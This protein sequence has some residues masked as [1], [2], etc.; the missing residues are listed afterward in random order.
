MALSPAQVVINEI[1]SKNS[2]VIL[3]NDSGS[4][5]WI[6]LYNTGNE[7]INL[8]NW[9][10][11]NDVNQPAKWRFPAIELPAD[12]HLVVMASGKNRKVIVDHWETIIHAEEIWKYWIPYGNPDPAW[13]NLNFDDSD[14][15]EGPGGFGRGDGDDNTILPD[16]VA[17]VYIRKTFTI[18]DTAVIKFASLHIDYD[19]AFVAYING[20]EVAR[21]NIGWPG[22][23]QHWD[24]F[25]YGIHTA[26]MLQGLP[27]EE[28]RI[29]VNFFKSIIN[30]GENVLAIQALN[31]WDNNGNSSIIPFLSVAIE[32]DS[33]TYQQVPEWFGEKPIYL[34]ANFKLSG[35]G[36]TLVL[37]DPNGN[38]ADN[39][40]FPY[41]KANHSYGRISDGS[42]IWQ[43]FGQ[44]TPETQ[45]ELS[46]PYSGYAKEPAV[47]IQ[48][49]FYS[50]SI[51]V[52][53]SNYQQGD[54]IR[55]SL[56]GSWP[57][58]TSAIYQGNITIDSTVVFRAQVFKTGYLPGKVITNTYLIN[59]STTFPVVSLSLNPHDL[60]DWDEGIYVMG[61]NAEPSFPFK[62]ANFW[63]DWAK[64][65]HIE[66][67]DIEQNL[68]FEQDVDIEIHGGYSRAYPM[69][70]LRIIANGKYDENRINYKLFKDKNITQFK[71]FI[72]RNSGQDYNYTHFRDALMQ[73]QVQF[74][75]D[76]DI[77]DY[78]PV[79]V[80]LNGEYWGVHNMREKIDKN[81][82]SQN[83]G[84][85]SDS[86]NI[87][88]EN[89]IIVAG[90]YWNYEKMIDY[91]ANVPVV[92]SAVYD[93]ISKLVDIDNYSDYFITEMYYVNH[94]WPNHNTKY[95]QLNNSTCRWRYITT[96]LDFGLGRYGEPQNNELYRVLH[97]NILWAHNHRIL[98]RLIENEDYRQYFINR[99]ADL[100]NTILLPVNLVNSIYRFKEHL[101]PEM[102]AHFER[103]GSS[104]A[105]WEANVE[106][107]VEFAEDR[108][109]FVWQ[110]YIDEFNLE[111]TVT[112]GLDIDSINHGKIKINTIIPDSLPWQGTYFDGNPV[113]ISAISDSGFVFSH[114]ASNNILQ[115]DDTLVQNLIV[116]VDTNDIFKAFFQIDT[117]T[118][119]VVFSEINYR[120]ADTLDADDW[121]E[122]LNMDSLSC[123][124][125]GWKFMDGDDTHEFII[126]EQTVL[127]TG[128]YLVIC[129]DMAKFKD[130]YPEIENV[131][132]SFGFGLAHGGEELRLFDESG[133]PVVSM[134]YSN[135]S[136]WP[137]NADGTGRTIELIDPY[138]D[139]NDGSNWFSG[140]LLGSPGG[141]FVECD[142][143][144][145]FEE[146]SFSDEI[147]VY[148]NPFNSN[149]IIEFNIDNAQQMSFTV[150]NTL[151]NIVYK[152]NTIQTEK[153]KNLFI[154]ERKNLKDGVYFF[155]LY[156]K[157]LFFT[158]KLFIKQI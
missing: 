99:S 117:I 69:K 62:G 89:R 16:S 116:N 22:R 143:V 101:A 92:D 111:K 154:F 71:K 88:R 120:S 5:D 24:D 114:W 7:T 17:T 142:T 47:N 26:V 109:G 61:P 30:E 107:A 80:F 148:P 115:G 136:P 58:D 155:R 73:K 112:I 9:S 156:G 8:E 45:N 75:T 134:T 15:L 135:Q 6:E 118:P 81:Y 66:Y 137:E 70:S 18:Y 48:S 49:G 20:V 35:Q 121:I 4:P 108:P 141:P 77:Q 151:G 149:T 34:H 54:T 50:G 83:H 152:E 153:G 72:L 67:F 130:I 56:D 41:L 145:I 126:P 19:D 90:N 138:G 63:M 13:A 74:K 64:P 85:P 44:P 86:L 144:G 106:Q 103:W 57:N 55:Y 31:A 36:G 46:T 42:S 125:S 84:V 100:F 93:S 102:P 51:P 21:I 27:P 104:Y 79:V 43:Y 124:L 11:S 122:I 37:A 139:L 38:I 87:L 157:D 133:I 40:E 113:E 32:D 140:C 97:G 1:C 23:I 123:N 68:G 132:G 96:D 10:I 110:Q 65:T 2:E 105:A 94:D 60:W 147:F 129:Q 150:Y 53:I 91:I 127:D 98:R 78:E 33:F 52:E 76:S 131:L 28:F 39:I 14:W 82:V 95:W 25:S 3:D 128:Q 146:K 59:Y 29:D 12:S 158:G 119:F